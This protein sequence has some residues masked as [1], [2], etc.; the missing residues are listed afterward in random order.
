MPSDCL[1][2]MAVVPTCFM[3]LTEVT[4][5]CGGLATFGG[6]FWVS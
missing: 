5:V 3:Y 4:A 2:V 6:K 1:R